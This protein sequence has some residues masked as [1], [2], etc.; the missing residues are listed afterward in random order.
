[1]SDVARFVVKVE[2]RDN[3]CAVWVGARSN[4]GRGRFSYRGR[5][6]SAHRVAYELFVGPIPNGL[7]IDHLC[8]NP[9]CVNPAHLEP[10][11]LAENNRRYAASLTHCRYG[12][13]LVP[14]AG[15]NRRHCPACQRRCAKAWRDRGRKPKAAL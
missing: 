13:P 1:M 8:R 6:A 9:L 15:Q 10:V 4:R 3:G 5:N 14:K 12:H 2:R 7:H 11:T